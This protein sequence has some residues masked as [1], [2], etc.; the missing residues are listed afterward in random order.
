MRHVSIKIHAESNICQYGT[1][2]GNRAIIAMGE[3][4]GINDNHNAISPEGFATMLPNK[5]NVSI[6]GIVTGITNCC[7]SESLSM[8]APIAANND[9][10]NRYP[11]IKKNTNELSII[12]QFTPSMD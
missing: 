12:V 3:V 8:N 6:S 2:K 9:A 10:Y 5:N 7:V 11:K 1:P 4:K